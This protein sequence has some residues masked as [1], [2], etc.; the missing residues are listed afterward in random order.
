MTFSVLFERG[1]PKSIKRSRSANSGG[2]NK[3][4]VK[5]KANVIKNE[6]FS[7]EGV[8]Q[9]DERKPDISPAHQILRYHD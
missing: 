8:I 5:K 1:K 3:P 4:D 6:L 2:K 9:Y 7:L